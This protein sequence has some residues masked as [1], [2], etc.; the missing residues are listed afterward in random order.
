M[1][2][3]S[4]TFINNALKTALEEMTITIQPPDKSQHTFDPNYINQRVSRLQYFQHYLHQQELIEY[5]EIGEVLETMSILEQGTPES[6]ALSGYQRRIAQ[7]IY[8]IFWMYPT[9]LSHFQGVSP[10]DLSYLNNDQVKK[11]ISQV[12]Q[13]WNYSEETEH[14]YQNKEEN[15]TDL[16]KLLFNDLPTPPY[17]NGGPISEFNLSSLCGSTLLP[18]FSPSF[19]DDST[20]GLLSPFDE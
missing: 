1:S 5:Y 13:Y 12:L 6:P 20:P 3:K 17:D 11:L 15:E 16:Q 19:W 18:Q 9:A 4:F 10:S 14:T 2:R 8:S 7:Y